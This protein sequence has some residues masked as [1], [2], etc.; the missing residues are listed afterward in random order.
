MPCYEPRD[1]YI[2]DTSY[3]NRRLI[4][5]NKRL[6][7]MLCALSDTLQW[8]DPARYIIRSSWNEKKA[9]ISYKEYQKWLA[10]HR[11]EDALREKRKSK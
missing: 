6:T 3:E 9:G 7:A 10:E 4:D 2:V 8:V 5:E 11:R 1:Q